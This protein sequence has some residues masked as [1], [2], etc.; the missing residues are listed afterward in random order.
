MRSGAGISRLRSFVRFA[1]SHRR[2]TKRMILDI[3]TELA[4]GAA[5]GG[6]AEAYQ[7]LPPRP[8][9]WRCCWK[10]SEQ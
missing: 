1:R 9:L 7:R 2:Q 5:R 10:Q 6:G 3:R 8:V 4:S